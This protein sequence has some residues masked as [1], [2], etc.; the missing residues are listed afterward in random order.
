MTSPRMMTALLPVVGLVAGYF[1]AGDSPQEHAAVERARETFERQVEAVVAPARKRYLAEL[2]SLRTNLTRDNDLQG[3]AAVNAEI[4]RV[5]EIERLWERHFLE[6]YW[7]VDYSNNAT[8]TYRITNTGTVRF[9]EGG[10]TGRIRRRGKDYV[11]DFGEGKIER[12]TFQPTIRVEHFDPDS[13][14]PLG[15]PTAIGTGVP[16]RR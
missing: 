6:G 15:A 13:L 5:T 4:D 12:L 10:L 1:A 2:K 7:Q 14:Y 16:T 8:R 9:I 11:L 3:V